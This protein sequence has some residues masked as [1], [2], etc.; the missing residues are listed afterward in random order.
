MGYIVK[1][2]LL[3]LAAFCMGCYL[4]QRIQAAD[5]LLAFDAIYEII[6]HQQII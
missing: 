1:P 2:S 3:F 4:I 5:V 6:C